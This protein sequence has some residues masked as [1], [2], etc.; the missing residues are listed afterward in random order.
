[1]TNEL[2]TKRQPGKKVVVGRAGEVLLSVIQEMFRE[3]QVRR[4]VFGHR[5]M[6][7]AFT[8]AKVGEEGISV[9]DWMKRAELAESIAE[10]VENR[11]FGGQK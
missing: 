6:D 8:V 2:E 7:A 4:D 5:I 11:V 3:G 9:K 10:N 1:M